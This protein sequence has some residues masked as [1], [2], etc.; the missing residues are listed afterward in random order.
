M[1]A[2]PNH[3]RVEEKTMKK[4]VVVL[5]ACAF[6]FGAG[7]GAALAKKKGGKGGAKMM[8]WTAEE[9]KWVEVPK[10][11]GVKMA[12]VWGNPKKGAHRAFHKFPGGWEVGLH[13]HSSPL[14]FAVVAG[15]LVS[16]PKDGTA[17]E[18]GVGSAA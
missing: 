1:S 17:K 4:S 12:V 6:A 13:H 7:A 10:S 3:E 8:S 14:M 5:V 15:T 9:L 2:A 11:N 18:L 16:T